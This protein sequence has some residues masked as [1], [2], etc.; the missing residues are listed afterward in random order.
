MVIRAYHDSFTILSF[1]L[2]Q[3]RRMKIA[4]LVLLCLAGAVTASNSIDKPLGTC[5]DSADACSVSTA[6]NRSRNFFLRGNP[7]GQLSI[8]AATKGSMKCRA[9]YNQVEE[10]HNDLLLCSCAECR[11]CKSCTR[12]KYRQCIQTGRIGVTYASICSVSGGMRPQ[13]DG[14]SRSGNHRAIERSSPDT[15]TAL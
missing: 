3:P 8:A 14:R 6:A 15:T 1:R 4:L 11:D 10:G 5:F 9:F 12:V 13:E 7:G 2:S